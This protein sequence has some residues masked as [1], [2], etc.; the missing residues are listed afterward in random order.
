MIGVENA[1]DTVKNPA[2]ASDDDAS[3][4][5]LEA[6]ELMPSVGQ[7]EELIDDGKAHA[8][9][10]N[11]HQSVDEVFSRFAEEQRASRE[12]DVV[13][14]DEYA[15]QQTDA[16]LQ[17]VHRRCEGHIEGGRRLTKRCQRGKDNNIQYI[18]NHTGEENEK[19]A[20]D[21]AHISGEL[22]RVRQSRRHGL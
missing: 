5:Y 13:A 18:T 2:D 11:K 21:R 12:I 3:N 22:E 15:S 19:A 10:R 17:D 16:Q 14:G 7:R 9:E 4:G 1:R 20:V 8:G 6:T